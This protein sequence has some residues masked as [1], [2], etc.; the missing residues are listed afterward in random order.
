MNRQ[1]TRQ[2]LL[3]TATER[4]SPVLPPP[5]PK[6]PLRRLALAALCL[7]AAVVLL[8]ASGAVESASTDLRAAAA[9]AAI[10]ALGC[11][12]AAGLGVVRN[13]YLRLAAAFPAPVQRIHIVLGYVV[14]FG[15]GTLVIAWSIGGLISGTAPL[16]SKHRGTVSVA[17]DPIYFWISVVFH[18]LLGL[19]LIGFGLYAAY[20]RRKHAVYLKR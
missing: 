2:R 18:L 8:A 14:V 5:R 7:V 11:V 16:I 6:R 1:V 15:L 20:R 17:D 10:A 19:F 4:I 9:L 13:V 12:I 3:R